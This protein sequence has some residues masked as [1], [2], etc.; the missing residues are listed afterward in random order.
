MNPNPLANHP[1]LKETA[2]AIVQDRQAGIARSQKIVAPGPVERVIRDVASLLSGKPE[3]ES[4]LVQIS[5]D[6]AA[7]F[8]AMFDAGHYA[9]VVYAA[10]QWLD[11][12]SVLSL[13]ELEDLAYEEQ[14]RRQTMGYHF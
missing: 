9:S 6:V 8:Q 10:G 4:P 5:R 1:L 2:W 14:Q 13:R 3:P 12:Q 11:V 7:K